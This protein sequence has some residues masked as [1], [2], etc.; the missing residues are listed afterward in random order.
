MNALV[1]H[2]TR[3]SLKESYQIFPVLGLEVVVGGNLPVH[4]AHVAMLSYDVEVF[5][6]LELH[7]RCR[8]CQYAYC[9]LL[10]FRN[11]KCEFNV[12]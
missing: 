2:F 7:S 6:V 11:F 8:S 9:N 3:D 5:M 12:A 4:C 10:K 1:L